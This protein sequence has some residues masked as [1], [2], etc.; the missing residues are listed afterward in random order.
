MTGKWNLG[1]LAGIGGLTAAAA[2][3]TGLGPVRA[4]ELADLRANQLLLQQRIDQLAQMQ[5]QAPPPPGTAGGGAT[6][7]LGYKAAPGAPTLGGSFPRSFL[8]PGT[9]T[10]IRV[11]GFVDFTALD[12]LN[13][14]GNVDGS[15]YGSNS[16]QNGTLSGLPL[17]GGFVPG[18]GFA[19]PSAV[20]RAPSRNNGVLDFSPQQSRLDVETRTPTS[21]GEARTFFAFDWAGCSAGAN[22][23][24]QTLQQAGG[25]SL[26]PRLRFAYGTLGGFLAGQALS[27]FSDADADTESME[28]GGAIGSTGGQ[29][30][31]QV[32][33]TV[34]GPYGSAFSVSAEN[35]WTT[36]VT[37][38]GF[39]SSDY[40]LA[41]IGTSSTPPQ[42]LTPAICNGVSCVG[43][44][45]LTGQ[46]GTTAGTTSTST[47]LANP[48]VAKA[49]N[50]TFASYWAQPW[51]HFDI[52]ALLRFYQINDGTHF[53]D[54]FT[55]FGGHFSGDLHPNWWGYNKDDFLFSFIVGNAIGNYASGGLAT[56]VPLASNFTQT[57][58]CSNPIPGRCTGQFAASNIIV[59][60]V[61]AFSTN[62]GYQ[63]WWTP[64]LRST[65]A[66]GYGNQD[67]NA[68]LIGPTESTAANKV[69]WNTFVNL[70]WNPVAFITTGVE[71]M[72]GHR[73]VV[74]NLAGHEHVAIY[75]FRVAF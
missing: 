26:L 37:P 19:N 6:Q 53:S 15:N 41:G 7:G 17:A 13:G 71:Y 56:M 29:R 58:A 36:V 3:L 9:D 72:Y 34:P 10:S 55:G 69:L 22:Y 21:W 70:V 42:Q 73:T 32:R 47:V 12:W 60:P 59:N 4:D 24:C 74:A 35:P 64:N 75:K 31:P 52:A 11:G 46:S 45:N 8:I 48:T 67:I 40:N 30:I 54:K 28:F 65:I 27:N 68:Q 33:Y 44:V 25:N 39:Q 20:A 51:G 61:F 14:G 63:H 1:R 38:G 2:L 23:T 66:A 16:G 49:P 62:G 43:S 18:I 5:A 50:L 57:T